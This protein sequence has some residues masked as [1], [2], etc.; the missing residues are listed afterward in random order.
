MTLSKRSVQHKWNSIMKIIASDTHRLHNALEL[1]RGKLDLS[2]ES[3]RRAD[4][5]AGALRKSGYQLSTPDELDR[6]LLHRVHNPEYIEFLATAWERWIE[7]YDSSTAAMAFTW[8]GRGVNPS[9]P[10]DLVGQLGYHSFS[11]DSS[12]VAGTW[13]AITA[14]AAIAQTAADQVASGAPC[15]YALCRPPGHHAT[16]DQFGGYCFLNNSAV[17]AQRLR[18]SGH[19]RVAILDIDYHHGNG[20]QD[21]FYARSDVVTL[22]IHADPTEEFPWFSGHACENGDGE[23]QGSNINLALARGANLQQ[24]KQ[25]LNSAIEHI[26]TSN[27]SALVVALGVDTYIDDPLGTFALNTE[28]YTDIARRITAMNL[29]T[30][31]VQEGGYAVNAIGDNVAAFLKPFG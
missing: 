31:I 21:I 2:T 14:A 5:I 27:V 1:S 30:V 23:G 25:A 26:A 7:R 17:A 29:P 3:P 4:I 19:A 13:S 8:P 12:I 15:A 20:T 16:K 11:A 28:D 10:T 24:W 6:E 18:D 9:R 22:S